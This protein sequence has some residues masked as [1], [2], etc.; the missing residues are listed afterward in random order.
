MGNKYYDPQNTDHSIWCI[1]DII[2][3]IWFIL[4]EKHGNL[5]IILC[6]N[7]WNMLE[8]INPIHQICIIIEEFMGILYYLYH[9]I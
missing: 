8:T 5:I 9:V 7:V 3:S 4:S 1:L 2:H 6:K